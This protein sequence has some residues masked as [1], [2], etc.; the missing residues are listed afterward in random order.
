MKRFAMLLFA[1]A[2]LAWAVLIVREIG[3]PERETKNAAQAR[4]LV[5]VVALVAGSFAFPRRR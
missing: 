3:A 1:V 2:A 4:T 5:L